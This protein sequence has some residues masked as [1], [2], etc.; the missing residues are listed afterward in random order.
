MSQLLFTLIGKPLENKQTIKSL[1]NIHKGKRCFIIGNG[2]S[3]T[4]DDLEMLAKNNDISFA[5]NSINL[6][7]PRTSWR[8]TYYSV[9]D[10]GL[11]RTLIDVASNIPAKY[12]FFRQSSYLFTRNVK[13]KCLYLNADGNRKHLENPHFSY[14]LS[15]ITYTLA[16]VTYVSIQLAVYMGCEEIYFLGVDN[17]Y[18]L[19]KQKDGTVRVNKELKSSYFSGISEKVSKACSGAKWEMDI[20]YE[21]AKRFTEE[22]GVK[23]YNA[24]RGG[25]LETFTSVDFDKLF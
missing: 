5:A 7:F 16:T 10:E 18:M 8:P 25:R 9:I 22:H 2:P 12:K 1:K 20:A 24:T 19:D 21:A 11:Q 17:N 6:I 15:S 13:G 14:D 3:L 4:S 23:I